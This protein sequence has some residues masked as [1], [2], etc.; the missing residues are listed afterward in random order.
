MQNASAVFE[1]IR[2]E[3]TPLNFLFATVA[4]SFTTTCI[5]NPEVAGSK[6]THCYIRLAIGEEVIG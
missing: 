6:P 5:R 3:G 2:V 4:Q 1:M